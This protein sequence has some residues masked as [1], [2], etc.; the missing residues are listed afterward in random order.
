M[1]AP[2][3]AGQIALLISAAPALAGRVEAVA[4]QP[5][6]GQYIADLLAFFVTEYFKT[7]H[8]TPPFQAAVK[9]Y[10]YPLESVAVCF[11]LAK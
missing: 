4:E 7:G 11:F 5:T 10:R 3:V 8:N 2:H 1:A 9:D 6:C